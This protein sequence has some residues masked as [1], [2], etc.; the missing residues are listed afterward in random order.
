MLHRCV[1]MLALLGALPA[2]AAAQ[3]GG[4][5]GVADSSMIEQRVAELS[6]RLSL[7]A[8]QEASVRVVLHE[9]AAH[10]RKAMREAGG[11]RD[12]MRRS[13]RERAMETDRRIEALLREEQKEAY[14]SY[15]EERRREMRKRFQEGERPRP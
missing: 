7:S 4:P 11:D 3:P 8:E 5:R 13:F 2:L 6:D 1:L 12:A 14:R 10:A 9:E 15:R